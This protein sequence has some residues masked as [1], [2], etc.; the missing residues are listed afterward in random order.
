M[1][2]DVPDGSVEDVLFEIDEMI[3][4]SD[5]P[6][7]ESVDVPVETEHMH[8]DCGVTLANDTTRGGWG[9]SPTQVAAYD[10]SAATVGACL[11]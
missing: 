3:S 4:F 7:M 8:S 1:E 10:M 11:H 6:D 2:F 9:Y 5:V